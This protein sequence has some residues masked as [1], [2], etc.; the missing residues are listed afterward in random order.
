MPSACYGQP[1]GRFCRVSPKLGGAS[2]NGRLRDALK[3]EEEFYWKVQGKLIEEGRIVPGRG[4]GGSV[5]LTAALL[6]LLR[7]SPMALPHFP[8]TISEKV[9]EQRD[10]SEIPGGPRRRK[11][12]ERSLYEPIKATIQ[13]TWIQVLRLR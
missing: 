7:P 10:L 1:G 13:T 4:R 5:R 9:P 3:W 6:R 8:E 2:G 12:T 11:P